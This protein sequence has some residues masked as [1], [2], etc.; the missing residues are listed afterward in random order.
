MTTAIAKSEDAVGPEVV[1]SAAKR[2]PQL[3]GV[4]G[5]AILLVLVW[6]YYAGGKLVGSAASLP[7]YH[8]NLLLLT[9]SGVE[10]FFVLS[11]FLIGGIL[12]DHRAAANYFPVFY[13][14]RACR[15]L[16]LYFGMVAVFLVITATPLSKLSYFDWLLGRPMPLLSYATFTQNIWMGLRGDFGPG[17][18]GA[19][20]S[21]AIEEQFYLVIP[22]LIYFLPRRALVVALPAGILMGPILRH[23]SPGFH[24]YV[25][26]PWRA[27]VLLSG[28]G[29]AMLV[30]SPAFMSAVH[31]QRRVLLGVCLALL[32]GI[33][34]GRI[35]LLEVYL[36]GLYALFIL[37]AYA[38]W[39]PQLG[40]LLRSRLL[41]WFG[42][43]SYGLYLFH[44]AINGLFHGLLRHNQ[45][46]LLSTADA[47]TTLLALGATLGLAE[48]SY[49]FLET[50]IMRFGHK[51][52]YA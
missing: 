23:F 47:L 18:L 51:V 40:W 10:L 19:T 49:R 33:G 31:R 29:L 2:V 48:L 8:A 30:R 20:W 21:L 32:A 7:V 25:E 35:D 15:I 16:P 34:G 12:L 28:V 13:R 38:D 27:D 36:A 26:A 44:E 52:R 41:V 3:D 5:V 1:P 22:L 14:R 37:I 24:A 9:R 45:P 46:Q 42:Q 17:W 43:R 39:Q 6:H 4:R 11:G 50:P